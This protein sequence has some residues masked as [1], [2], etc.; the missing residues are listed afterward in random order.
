[1]KRASNTRRA[2]GF[3]LVELLL[4]LAISGLLLAA[5]AAAFNASVVSYQEN[6]EAYEMVNN[7]RQ[8]LFRMT[9]QLRTAG[10]PDP[11]GSIVA[12]TPDDPDDPDAASRCSFYTSSG[13]DIT[14]EFRSA[15]KRLYLI[16]NA[17]GQEYVLCGNVTAATF[18]KTP[19]PDGDDCNNVQIS[20]SVGSGGRT[21]TFSSSVAIRRK[22]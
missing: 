8:A 2:E 22:L 21:R 6:R 11:N 14:Y 5:V 9:T 16:T 3:T 1:M 12:V 19:T 7:A 13:E 17:D 10:S 4:G 15:D 18:T 20:M